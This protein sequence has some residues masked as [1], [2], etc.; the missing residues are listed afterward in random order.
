MKAQIMEGLVDSV[1][2]KSKLAEVYEYLN[3]VDSIREKKDNLNVFFVYDVELKDNDIDESSINKDYYLDGIFIKDVI[4]LREKKTKE[5]LNNHG[6]VM[7]GW[8]FDGFY[9]L[10]YDACKDYTYRYVGRLT[11]FFNQRYVNY[12]A[13]LFYNNQIDCAFFY[14]NFVEKTSAVSKHYEKMMNFAFA[15]KQN[16]LFVI[17]ETNTKDDNTY[18]P[19]LI[20]LKDY[21]DCCWEE[22][23]NL[24][25]R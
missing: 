14:P 20:Y 24:P 18:T 3:S 10:I 15:V 5:M 8:Y 23:T 1:L 6:Y 25:L 11:E 21:I 13:K 12:I 2:I 22:M 17:M 9:I 7:Q 16:D 4:N 19:S